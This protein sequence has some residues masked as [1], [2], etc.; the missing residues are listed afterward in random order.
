MVQCFDC[1]AVSMVFQ[2]I[3]VL[4]VSFILGVAGIETAQAVVITAP[5]FAQSVSEGKAQISPIGVIWGNINGSGFNAGGYGFN[6]CLGVGANKR[7]FRHI[8]GCI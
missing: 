8:C 5:A 6:V 1:Y 3:I 2:T 4:F 7:L